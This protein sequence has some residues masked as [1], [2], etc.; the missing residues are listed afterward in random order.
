MNAVLAWFGSTGGLLFS[1]LPAAE[2]RVP[3]AM[4]SG[5]RRPSLVGPREEYEAT[6]VELPEPSA[7]TVSA[8]LAW[9]GWPMVVAAEPSLP[10]ENTISRS[11]CAHSV[12]S[13]SAS[14]AV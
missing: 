12:W 8:C 10:A 1:V 3:G 9:P 7:P 2:V 11:S 4:M 6:V 5:L 14:L 13:T